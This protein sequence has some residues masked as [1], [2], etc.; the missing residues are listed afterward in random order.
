MRGAPAAGAAE[1]DTRAAQVALYLPAV[2]APP[3]AFYAAALRELMASPEE[4]VSLIAEANLTAGQLEE[5]LPSDSTARNPQVRQGISPAQAGAELRHVAYLA[6]G[7]TSP[8]P[9]PA[10]AHSEPFYSA[11]WSWCNAALE[12]RAKPCEELLGDTWA[13]VAVQ[14]RP[15]RAGGLIVRSTLHSSPW[16]PMPPA[17]PPAT[18]R[19]DRRPGE[20]HRGSVC[21]A[22]GTGPLAGRMMLARERA[23][24]GA[25]LWPLRWPGHFAQRSSLPVY[26]GR[27]GRH[28]DV[29]FQAWMLARFY[30]TR[31]LAPARRWLHRNV[32]RRRR[33]RGFVV[34]LTQ[35]NIYHV[36]FHAVPTQAHAAR[37]G[38]S[39]LEQ[40]TDFLPRYTRFWPSPLQLVDLENATSKAGRWNDLLPVAKWRGWELIMRSLLPEAA[41]TA[42]LERTQTIVSV[43]LG[44]L[45]CYESL[46]G[47]HSGFW[48]SW[49]DPTRIDATHAPAV[50]AF[51]RAFV[52]RQSLPSPPPSLTGAQS[53]IVFVL[54]RGN[55]A[56]VNEDALTQRVGSSLTLQERVRFV[57][58][59]EMALATQLALAARSTALVGLTGQALSFVVFLT[60]TGSAMLEIV[61]RQMLASNSHAVFDFPRWARLSLARYFRVVQTDAPECVGRNFRLC[62]NVTADEGLL[63]ALSL[64]ASGAQPQ[65]SVTVRGWVCPKDAGEERTLSS[66]HKGRRPPLV[67]LDANTS[68]PRRRV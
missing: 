11:V 53:D 65:C 37:L 7:G 57:R 31:T 49:G 15:T 3:T 9:K 39:S 20:W 21:M 54:R 35:D 27:A 58:L 4:P 63:Q 38:L 50:A 23:A 16:E 44:S 59:E 52:A 55:R 18:P 8:P 64:V 51:R 28:H 48:P 67:T 29:Q 1:P 32:V 40:E 33:R 66:P 47:G 10:G 34:Q 60:G 36:L 24:G 12:P 46:H 6:W 22:Y 41:L 56:I 62:G 68:P 25:L 26:D 17:D 61:P 14:V 5:L 30:R 2:D 45:Q 43:E 42:A 13:A 19:H